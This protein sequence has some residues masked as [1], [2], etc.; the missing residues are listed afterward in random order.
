MSPMTM[1]VGMDVGMGMSVG[2]GAVIDVLL[3]SCSASFGSSMVT[4]W[5]GR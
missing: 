4:S 3:G 2:V 5:G 1:C